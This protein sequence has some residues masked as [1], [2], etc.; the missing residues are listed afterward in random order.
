MITV[1]CCS[2]TLHKTNLS[3]SAGC[4]SK[5]FEDESGSVLVKIEYNWHEYALPL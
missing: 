1:E 5:K 3:E 4:L 2:I